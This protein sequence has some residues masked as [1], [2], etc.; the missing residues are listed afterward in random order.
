VD[1]EGI[2]EA[3]GDDSK[4]SDV[5]A[6]YVPEF[7]DQVE[8]VLD[9]LEERGVASRFVLVGLC[10]GGYWSFR[11]ALRDLRVS[12][13]LLLNAGALKWHPDLIGD[14]EARK[15]ARVLSRRWWKKF[16][17]GEI[18]LERLLAIAR[19]VLGK[20]GQL[21][22][23]PLRLLTGRGNA[24]VDRSFDADFDRLRD[25]D[26][27]LT[28]AFSGEEPL[29]A[30]LRAEGIPARLERWPSIELASLPGD[31]HTLRAIS[32]QVAAREFLDGELERAL[33]RERVAAG[34]SGPGPAQPGA[35]Q[36]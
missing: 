27:R 3:D 24:S 32:A 5:A 26:T 31:D 29:D 23:R 6:F 30:E 34:D 8:T 12:T 16:L 21:A 19:S 25:L 14:R 33:E 22:R 7:E 11:T 10:A 18:G 9:S 17:S 36:R 1:L 4:R 20:M 15:L 28:M 13:A 35:R 2:G